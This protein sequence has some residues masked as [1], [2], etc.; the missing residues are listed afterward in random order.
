RTR[1]FKF[2]TDSQLSN[3]S[4]TP[5]H[6][7]SNRKFACVHEIPHF[8]MENRSR[9]RNTIITR[10]R[11]QMADGELTGDL[12]DYRISAVSDGAGIGEGAIRFIDVNAGG[13]PSR[14]R[15]FG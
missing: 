5:H 1:Q 3:S 14:K 12:Q 6:R 4:A 11:A 2:R 10:Q 13:L 9:I 7:G 15:G 8:D